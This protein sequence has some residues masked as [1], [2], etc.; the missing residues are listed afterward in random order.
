MKAFWIYTFA[1]FAVFAVTFSFVW[2][3]ASVVFE[4]SSLVNLL[5]LLVSLLISS[6]ISVFALA[7]LRAQLAVNIQQRATRMTQRLEESRS[8]EDVD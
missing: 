8:A 3:L 5:V 2:L 7:G 6:I 4:S 1:R